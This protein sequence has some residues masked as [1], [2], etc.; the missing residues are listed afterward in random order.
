MPSLSRSFRKYLYDRFKTAYAAPLLLVAH[1][2]H[3]GFRGM[4][5][6]CT[7]FSTRTHAR[8]QLSRLLLQ[9]KSVNTKYSW[10]DET[11]C[12]YNSC[13]VFKNDLGF[14]CLCCCLAGL[15]ED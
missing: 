14:A 6:I 13:I 4:V 15:N 7:I 1:L 11:S 10:F 2:E 5:H 12:G 3:V 8:M 9:R